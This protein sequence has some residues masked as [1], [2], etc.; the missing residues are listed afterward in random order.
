MKDS[1]LELLVPLLNALRGYSI[2]DEIRPTAFY[3]RGRDLIHFHETEQGVVADVLLSRGRVQMPVST[4]A[5]QAALLEKIE[6][7]LGS[8]ESH[9]ARSRRRSKRRNA[10]D[11]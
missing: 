8:L 9:S 1:T 6:P 3:L 4:D 5:Q 10:R 7:Q 11:A 2:L